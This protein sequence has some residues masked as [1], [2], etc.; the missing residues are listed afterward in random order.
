MS[1]DYHT[2]IKSKMATSASSSTT[3]FSSASSGM[4]LRD[5]YRL[6]VSDDATIWLRRKGLIGDFTG[7]D[8]LKCSKGSMKLV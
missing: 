3:A 1:H 8:Y 7:E 4:L 6:T 2:Y 5:L